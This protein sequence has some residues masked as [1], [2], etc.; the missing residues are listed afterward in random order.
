[1]ADTSIGEVDTA[2]GTLRC[3][4]AAA[5]AVNSLA[6]GYNGM[7]ARL[8][9][10]DLDAYVAVA[11][12]GLGKRPSEVEDKVYRAGVINLTGA[13]VTYVAYLGNGGKPVTEA[14][15]DGAPAGEA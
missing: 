7:M 4:L 2:V 5:K 6:G 9:M 12:A 11:A 10:L 3:S 14:A 13:F 1:M 15:G 8:G